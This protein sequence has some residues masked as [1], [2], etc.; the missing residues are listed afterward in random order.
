MKGSVNSSQA[1]AHSTIIAAVSA[2]PTR[3]HTLHDHMAPSGWDAFE[4][5]G[6]KPPLDSQADFVDIPSV[7][8]TVDPMSVVGR[9]FANAIR[10][11]GTVFPQ[12]PP[13]L[14][15]FTGFYAGARSGYVTHLVAA[16]GRLF[17]S[18]SDMRRWRDYLSG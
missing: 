7:A 18:W 8:G 6:P 15:R 11:I 10:S 16:Q 1:R 17:E 2:F 14:D 12:P 3:L 4:A 13:G 9:D 5:A